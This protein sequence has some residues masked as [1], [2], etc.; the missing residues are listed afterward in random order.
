[1]PL[2]VDTLAQQNL[3]TQ[4]ATSQAVVSMARE[5]VRSGT[6]ALDPLSGA[7]AKSRPDRITVSLE[8]YSVHLSTRSDALVR[9]SKLVSFSGEE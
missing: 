1:M 4:S 5:A 6:R 8:T 2:M 3:L 9:R 7:R